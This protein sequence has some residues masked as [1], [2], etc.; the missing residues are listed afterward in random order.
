MRTRR[1]FRHPCEYIKARRAEPILTH[2]RRVAAT[3]SSCGAYSM[4]SSDSWQQLCRQLSQKSR[5]SCRLNRLSATDMDSFMQT[6][7]ARREAQSDFT[8]GNHNPSLMMTMMMMK[9]SLLGRNHFQLIKN[10]YSLL[11]DQLFIHVACSLL[12]FSVLLPFQTVPSCDLL[13]REQHQVP[14]HGCEM[15]PF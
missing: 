6:S 5:M 9:H 2:G 1:M 14:P 12:Y 3:W 13:L 7:A 10:F 11:S 15:V 4:S 8:A